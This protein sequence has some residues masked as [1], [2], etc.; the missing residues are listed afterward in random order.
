MVKAFESVIFNEKSNGKAYNLTNESKFTWLEVI[1]N[2][3]KVVNK[4]AKVRKIDYKKTHID[5]RNFFP[6]RDVTYLLNIDN[7]KEDN[8]Y[9]PETDLYEGL[10]KTFE[11]Y[12]NKEI[13]LSDKRMS[14]VDEVLKI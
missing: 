9:I 2:V 7:L 5:V 1:E 14:K 4:K 10:S 8:M 6:Y 11:W 13:R 3:E 12:K